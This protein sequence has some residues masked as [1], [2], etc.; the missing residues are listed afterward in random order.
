[1]RARF[2]IRGLKLVIGHWQIS[3]VSCTVIKLEA[4]LYICPVVPFSS[5]IAILVFDVMDPVNRQSYL[6]GCDITFGAR[7]PMLCA[8]T[9]GG[10]SVLGS[11][12]RSDGDVVVGGSLGGAVSFF[13]TLSI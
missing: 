13:S 3:G 1:M 9:L 2:Q 6:S 5:R 7:D 11:T 8:G 4:M 12:L 10:G